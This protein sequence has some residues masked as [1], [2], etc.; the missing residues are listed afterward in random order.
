MPL[1]LFISRRFVSLRCRVVQ[2][3][4]GFGF[5]FLLLVAPCLA[6]STALGPIPDGAVRMTSEDIKRLFSGVTDN[7]EVQDSRG[8]SAVNYWYADGS[9][10]NR[11]SNEVASGEVRGTWSA[12]NGERCIVI[13]SGLPERIGI[14]R[15]APLYQQGSKIY[16]L[17][18]DGSV[19][20]VHRLSPLPNSSD[21]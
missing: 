6:E 2:D 10:V 17:N 20:G 4:A 15:C 11:W 3:V 16:S 18:P 9:F 12:R 7:A 19:H 1:A 5:L 8:T 13:T 14:E 21:Q